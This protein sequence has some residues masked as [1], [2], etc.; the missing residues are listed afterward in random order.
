MGSQRVTPWLSGFHAHTSLI[1]AV[2]NWM[3]VSPYN[4]YAEVLTTTPKWWCL[5]MGSVGGNKGLMGVISVEFPQWNSC[6]YKKRPESFLSRSVHKEVMWAHS[7]KA[8]THSTGCACVMNH[9]GLWGSCLKCK[10]ERWATHNRLEV[11]PIPTRQPKERVSEF[12][13]S[14]LHP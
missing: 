8:P 3:L 2:V 7:T 11:V 12:K 6:L 14:Q 13:L 1:A 9:L 10:R 4:S 5:E